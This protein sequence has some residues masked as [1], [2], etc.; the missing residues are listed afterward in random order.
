MA[1]ADFAVLNSV[2]LP[3][4]EPIGLLESLPAEVVAEVERWRDHLMEMATGLPSGAAHRRAAS[5]D[6]S[7]TVA[8]ARLQAKAAELGIS[9]R[10]IER[11]CDRIEAQGLWV[12]STSAP[13]ARSRPPARLTRGW[14]RC[15]GS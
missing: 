15:C 8:A 11:K 7:T 14:S 2:S 5:F 10:T 6:P 12:W 4:T 13:R 3:V 1:A 9:A